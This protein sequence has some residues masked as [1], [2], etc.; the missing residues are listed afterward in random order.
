MS[1]EKWPEKGSEGGGGKP[2]AYDAQGS[3]V[4]EEAE[5]KKRGGAVKKKRARGGKIE[6]EKPKVRMDRPCRASGGRVGSDKNP[7]S[8][9]AKVSAPM[10]HSTDD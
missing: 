4:E 6:G 7:L 3:H 8:S 9:A 10:G 1:K 2:K 5:E